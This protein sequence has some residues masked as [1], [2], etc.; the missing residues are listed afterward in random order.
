[1]V[2][3]SPEGTNGP[4]KTQV[5]NSQSCHLPWPKALPL[6]SL[7][8][9]STPFP[10]H[11]PPPLGIT[12]GRRMELDGGMYEPAL[13][14]GGLP[15]NCTELTRAPKTNSVHRA[16]RA[17]RD[18]PGEAFHHA[19]HPDSVSGKCPL[20]EDA[21]LPTGKGRI[22]Y[23]LLTLV[24]LLKGDPWTHVSHIKRTPTPEWS[25]P[26]AGDLKLKISQPPKTSSRTVMSLQGQIGQCLRE[27]ALVR[28]QTRPVTPD[29]T[30]RPLPLAPL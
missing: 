17:Q 27:E 21:L 8:L 23:D 24:L 25:S 1:M 6:V 11:R 2:L 26:L 14:K 16:S 3:L 10:K 4:I 9:R 22:G 28:P 18:P 12:T 15:I 5:Q 30:Q 19:P 13:R 7:N 20:H 29:S